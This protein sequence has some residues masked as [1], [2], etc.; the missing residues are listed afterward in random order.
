MRKIERAVLKQTIERGYSRTESKNNTTG[1]QG[2]PT[3]FLTEYAKQDVMAILSKYITY[4]D[5]NNAYWVDRYW[6]FDVDKYK[7][8]LSCF[9]I[10]MAMPVLEPVTIP[11]NKIK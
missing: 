2:P 9:G 3:D 7:N 11:K 5:H 4:K 1:Y 6:Y 10:D 8:D